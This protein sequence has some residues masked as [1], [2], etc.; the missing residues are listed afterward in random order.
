M[1]DYIPTEK[2]QTVR[3]PSTANLMI[4]SKDR[5]PQ[6]PYPSNFFIQK[7]NSILNG[8]FTR[9]GVTEVVLD[10]AEPTIRGDSACWFDISCNGVITTN[11]ELRIDDA[12]WVNSKE[13]CDEFET[14]S[15]DPTPVGDLSGVVFV[16]TNPRPGEVVI[17]ID[18]GAN[19]PAQFRPKKFYQGDTSFP[20]SQQLWNKFGINPPETYSSNLVGWVEDIS[21]FWVDPRAYSYID[22]VSPELTYAQDLKDATT[23]NQDKNVL[24]RFYFAWDDSAG[25]IYDDYGFPLLMGTRPFSQRKLFSPP[26]QIKW[27]PNLPIGNLSFQLVTNEGQFITEAENQNKII[28]AFTGNRWAYY[29]GTNFKL[30]LQVSEV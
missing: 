9:I 2:G 27:E 3:Q 13:F 21:T 5:A 11:Y 19:P 23:G 15:I 10:W 8:Y 7:N 26:K 17:T 12:L 30:T 20:P 16:I 4:D 6:Y 14:I 25:P 22:I 18:N 29:S 28:G 1:V 24:T